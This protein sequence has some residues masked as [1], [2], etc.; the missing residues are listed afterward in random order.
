MIESCNNQLTHKNRSTEC[1]DELF[2]SI[3]LNVHFIKIKVQ[4]LHVRSKF[5]LNYLH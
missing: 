3:N 5:K 1:L 2:I 4:Y